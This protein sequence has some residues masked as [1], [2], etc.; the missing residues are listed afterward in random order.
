MDKESDIVYWSEIKIKLKNKYPQLTSADLQWRHS[1]KED[2]ISTIA[3]KLGISN[4][5]FQKII[6]NF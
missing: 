1:T 2:L 6:D 5:E 3:N 4:N